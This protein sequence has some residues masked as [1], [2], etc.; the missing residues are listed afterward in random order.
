[1]FQYSMC[2]YIIVL[3]LTT[4]GIRTDVTCTSPVPAKQG[5]HQNAAMW[6]FIIFSDQLP[7]IL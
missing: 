2:S 4:V 3:T 6:Q 7:G 5:Q 1:M